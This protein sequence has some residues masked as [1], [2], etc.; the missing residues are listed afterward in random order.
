MRSAWER[1]NTGVQFES[2]GD[3]RPLRSLA[4]SVCAQVDYRLTPSI[5]LLVFSNLF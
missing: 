2:G 3:G 5:F 4:A 1:R